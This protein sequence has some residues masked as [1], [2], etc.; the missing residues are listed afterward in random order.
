M[1]NALRAAVAEKGVL[2]VVICVT[3]RADESAHGHVALPFFENPA[4][5]N[6]TKTDRLLH[7]SREPAPPTRRPDRVFRSARLGWPCRGY[8][9]GVAQFGR[10]TIRRTVSIGVFFEMLLDGARTDQ[11][12]VRLLSEL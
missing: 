9:R 7:F 2:V 6:S 3:D 5:S 4:V 8:I 1:A 11:V 12:N 10:R